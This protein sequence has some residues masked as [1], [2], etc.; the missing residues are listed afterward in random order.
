MLIAL[1]Y[2]LRQD[3][4]AEGFSAD[5]VAEFDRPDTIDALEHALRHAGHETVRV[6]HARALMARLAAGER[7]DLVFNIAEGLLGFGRE[8]LVPA[9][10]DAH[11]IPY[12][13]SDPLVCAVTLHKATAKRIL[14]DAGLPT[15]EFAVVEDASQCEQIGLPYPLFAKPVAEG[16]SKGVDGRAKASDPAS[17]VSVC[18]DLLRRFRQPVLVEAYLPGREVTVGL[19]GTGDRT[20]VV[21]VLEVRLLTADDAEIYTYANKEDCETRVQYVLA[22]DA[23]AEECAALALEAWRVI[24]AR[25]GGRVDL[26]ADGAGRPKVIEINPLPGMHPEHSDLPIM[27]SLLGRPYDELVAAILDSAIARTSTA[28]AAGAP[29]CMS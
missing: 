21:G 7:W 27:W 22:H 25:D 10:L 29:T 14:R 11:G 6:G 4:L 18:R 9:L 17:L 3:Y 12:V 1:T 28:H 15:P 20:R 5:D 24:G 16:S 26:R 8:S 13:F 2:D 23:F 19:V